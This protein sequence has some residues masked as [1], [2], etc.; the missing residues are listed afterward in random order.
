[1]GIQQIE[2]DLQRLLP[3]AEILRIDSDTH[4]KKSELYTESSHYD[5]VLGTYASLGFLQ[6]GVS[7]VVCM[8]F[9]SDLTLPDY[10]MEE[11][12]YHALE[13]MKKSGKNVLIQTYLP[14]HPLLRTILDGNYRDF[15][16]TM[17]EERQKFDYPPYAEFALIR[18]HDTS[19]E[20]VQDIIAKLVNK[21]TL[22]KS[23]DI[24]LA[25][26]RDISEKYAG[27]WIQKIILKGKDL[28]PILSELQVEI[29]RNRAVTLEWR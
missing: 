2:A 6:T 20:K 24:F 19:K 14:E 29:L 7:H 16:R 23:E 13:Y 3:K 27:E 25:Y 12:V 28:S 15:L 18:V 10:R 8:L 4:K 1:M 21:I 9:E 17:S 26:D 5:I 22:L 11:E